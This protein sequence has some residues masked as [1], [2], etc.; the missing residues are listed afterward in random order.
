MIVMMSPGASGA[1]HHYKRGGCV[2]R[3]SANSV[4]DTL[5]QTYKAR[6][7][8]SVFFLVNGA[9]VGAWVPFIPERAHALGMSA[10]SLGA[11][12]LGAGVGAVLM[13][14]IAGSLIPRFGSRVVSTVCG[15]CF[16]AGLLVNVTVPTH[17]ALLL[18]LFFFGMSGAGMSGA[19]MDVS[20]NAQAVLVENRSGVRILSS[21]HGLFSLGN[22]LG[23][24][25]VSAAFA[26]HVLPRPLAAAT[27]A[28]LALAIAVS[29]WA[30]LGDDAQ[31]S[32]H[33]HARQ[34]S[35]S[36]NPRLLFLGCLVVGAMI[37]EGGTGDWS[38]LYLRSA[39]GLGPG[40]AGVGFGVFASLMLV[41]RL[42]GDLIVA[43]LGEVRTLQVGGLV[44]AG[45]ALLVVFGPG[46]VGALVGFALF[47][48]GLAN[49]SPVLYRAAGKV[50]GIPAGVG[51]QRLW[52][53][54]TRACWPGHRCWE[55]LGR[56]LG[57][58]PS[59]W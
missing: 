44:A 50:P 59:F 49:V 8:T 43:R 42:L 37:C 36:F 30:M 15:L 7:A 28:V 34:A 19:G 56:H 20:M 47:G 48:T 23:S 5:Q 32:P 38:G 39:R 57:S 41:G 21:L 4:G 45:G 26:R 17:W 33:P 52:G 13:M 9:V 6:R 1:S 22:V 18:A 51:W 27:S 55:A 58:V 10:G 16:A 2:D 35:R 14:P 3:L 29:G 53:W 12:L 25:G 24:F 46:A 31:G 40:W 54:A 11:V